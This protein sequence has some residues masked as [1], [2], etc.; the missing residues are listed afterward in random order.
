MKNTITNAAEITVLAPIDATET[1]GGGLVSVGATVV[2]APRGQPNTVLKVLYSD[3]Q[4]ILGKP[5]SKKVGGAKMEG[6]RH[7]ADALRDCDYVNVVRVVDSTAEYPS[8]TMDDEGVLVKDGNAYP[9]VPVEAGTGIVLSIWVIDGDP[10]TNRKVVVS[11][12]DATTERFKI[13][14]TDLDENGETDP[15]ATET[16]TVGLAAT[17]V[18]DMGLPAFIETV[19]ENNSSRYRCDFNDTFTFAQFSTAATTGLAVATTFTGGTNG[20]TP[21]SEEFIAAWDLFRNESFAAD[22]M[23]AAGSLDTDVLA[24]CAAIAELRHN[25]F[26]FDASPAIKHDAAITWIATTSIDS[27]QARCYHAPFS[28]SDR[29]YGGQTVWGVSGEMAAAHARGNAIY[30]GEVPGIHYAAAGEKRAKLKRTGIKPLYADDV[31]DRDALYTARINPVIVSSSGGAVCD[32]DLAVY[33]K[34]NYER[35][36][37]V[38][39]ILNYIDHRFVQAA[40]AAKFEPD[41]I[42][43]ESLYRRSDQFLDDLVMSGGLVPPRDPAYGIEPYILTVTQQEIDLWLVLWE[44]CPTG[45]ARRIAGQPKLIK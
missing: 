4:E 31:L 8:I 2:E 17:D 23:F 16:Y 15:A 13:T 27:R 34:E 11:D 3:W 20:G 39:R 14:F 19:L 1:T 9:V 36:G 37:W 29:F 43:Y 41:G 42:T 35:F 26:L 33:Y 10:S 38:N 12:I 28:A 44:I 30:S 24:N 6:L 7:V 45:A 18:D 5:F 21:T 22:L 40:S 25:T 32:D